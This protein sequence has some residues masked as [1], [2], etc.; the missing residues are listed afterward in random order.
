MVH[1]ER[2]RSQR[3][4]DPLADPVRRI[5]GAGCEGAAPHRQRQLRWPDRH[6][7]RAPL[8]R[9]DQFRSEVPRLRQE[10]RRAA[11]GDGAA[12]G[13]QRD[14]GDLFDQGPPIHRDCLRRRQEW[15]PVRQLHRRIRAATPMIALLLALLHLVVAAPPTFDS[16]YARLKQGRIY[17]K[18]VPTG[19]LKKHHGMFPYWLVI[20][21]SY[22]PANKYQVRFQL[23]GGVMREDASLRGDGSV[24]LEGA[25]QIY[26]MPAGWSAAPWWSDAQVGSIRA[27]LDDIKRDYNVD[28]NR[29]YLSG[30]SDGGTG[31]YYIATRDTTPYAA[32]LPLNGYVMVLR[33]PE[34]ELRASIFLNNLRNKPFFIVNGGR[35]PLYPASL[36]EPSIAHL[37]GG[38]V[39]ITYLPQPEAGHDTSWWPTVKASFEQFA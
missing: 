32:F 33:S 30:V 3:G 36:V 10:Y 31:T 25:E 4:L 9:R 35:D 18:N 12:C 17:A 5:S 1:V 7:E 24:R 21:A 2:E 34:L 6:R 11:L 16:E 29:V 39:R 28:E 38:G 23:H 37:N 27:I 15:R 20:P 26:V 8:H 22:D 13:G 19:A 14:A